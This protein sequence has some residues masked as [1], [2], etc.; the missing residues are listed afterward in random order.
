MFFLDAH[1]ANGQSP[2]LQDD[3][4]FLRNRYFHIIHATDN[5]IITMTHISC[6]AIDMVYINNEPIW[7]TINAH[8]HATHVLYITEN[9]PHSQ[10][11]D[12]LATAVIEAM[13]GT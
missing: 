12:S 6:R 4:S 7:K 9:A 10:L 1:W 8:N 2:Q 3:T 5:M 11:P 13:Q